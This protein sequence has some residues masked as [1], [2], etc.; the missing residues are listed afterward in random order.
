[1][2]EKEFEEMSPLE[3]LEAAKELLVTIQDAVKDLQD[4]LD[5]FRPAI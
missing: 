1:M 4:L 3:H 5:D 2:T